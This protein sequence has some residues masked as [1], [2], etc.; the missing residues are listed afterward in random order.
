MGPHRF[1]R[2]SG[3]ASSCQSAASSSKHQIANEVITTPVAAPVRSRYNQYSST[4]LVLMAN[5]RE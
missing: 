1:L 2:V 4:M 5:M 3:A